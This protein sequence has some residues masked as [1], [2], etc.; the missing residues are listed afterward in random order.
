MTGGLP[1]RGCEYTTP[2]GTLAVIVA[3]DSGTVRAS[4]FSSLADLVA[5]LPAPLAAL[6]VERDEV[7]AVTRAIEQ[8]LA[9]DPDAILRVPVEQAGGAFFQ[10]VWGA[11]RAIPGGATVTYGE[12]AASAGNPKAAR[13]AGTAC[14]RNAVAP[15]VPC[16]RVVASTGLGQYGFGVGV[17]D[18]MLRLEGARP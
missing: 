6:G 7:P 1:L 13:A 10:R 14:A 11:M 18:A 15:F 2:F 8:W 16:H 17:K 3:P 12:L 4:G 5:R 9:G